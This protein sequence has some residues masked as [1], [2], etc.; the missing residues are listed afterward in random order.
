MER[1]KRLR[2]AGVCLIIAAATSGCSTPRPSASS[3]VPTAAST[4]SDDAVLVQAIEAYTVFN[5]ALDGYLSGSSELVALRPFTT[6]PF[7][8]KLQSEEGTG[9]TRVTGASSIDTVELVDDPPNPPADAD[10]AISLCRDVSQTS[11]ISEGGDR[12]QVEVQRVPLIVYLTRD[13]STAHSFLISEVKPWSA[14]GYCT[15]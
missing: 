3:P 2:A 10:L 4:E 12:E 11:V 1:R 7:Y 8:A 6:D 13:T 9:A 14:P 15:R 5:A